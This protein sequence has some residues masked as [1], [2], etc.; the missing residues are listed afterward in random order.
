MILKKKRQ[1]GIAH[2]CVKAAGTNL[3]ISEETFAEGDV[4]DA[5]EQLE[6]EKAQ[7]EP[8]YPVVSKKKDIQSHT[9][10]IIISHLHTSFTLIIF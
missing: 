2:T 7:E 10:Y 5:M 3:L 4:E 8:D 1:E 9:P 6:K